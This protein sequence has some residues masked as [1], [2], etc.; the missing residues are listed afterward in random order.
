LANLLDRFKVSVIGSNDRIRDYLPN[1]GAKGDFQTT[2]D[3]N[4]IINSWRNILLTPRRNYPYD[5]EY[6]SDLYK[7]V[8]DPLDEITVQRIEDEVYGSIQRYDNR[9]FID[10]I[11]IKYLKLEKGVSIDIYIDYK[12]D[13][14]ILSIIL[15]EQIFSSLLTT[16]G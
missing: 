14:G 7:M 16:E 2:V 9:A 8:F 6:G 11:D 1:I 12:G 10:D 5:P 13:K 3:L 15:N 4:V